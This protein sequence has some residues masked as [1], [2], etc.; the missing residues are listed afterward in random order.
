MTEM[1][2]RQRFRV[3]QN[4]RDLL[5]RKEKQVEKLCDELHSIKI[6]SDE[7]RQM[8]DQLNDELEREMKCRVKCSELEDEVT[9][10][11][12]LFD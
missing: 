7:Q 12:M 5:T 3:E 11:V 10:F 8:I 1:L 9:G 4:L 6:F 2:F